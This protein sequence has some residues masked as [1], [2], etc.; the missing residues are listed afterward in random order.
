M[1]ILAKKSTLKNRNK[2]TRLDLQK[3]TGKKN[4]S[5]DILTRYIFNK[6]VAIKQMLIHIPIL[7]N[8]EFLYNL[9]ITYILHI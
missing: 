2:L 6:Y 9:V 8:Q 5:I 1:S 3:M 4:D 7:Y